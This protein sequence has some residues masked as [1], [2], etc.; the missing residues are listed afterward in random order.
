MAWNLPDIF[1]NTLKNT[2]ALPHPII[3]LR[4]SFSILSLKSYKTNKKILNP[5]IFSSVSEL[6]IFSNTNVNLLYPTL[7]KLERHLANTLLNENSLVCETNSQHDYM[8]NSSLVANLSELHKTLLN[9]WIS[10]EQVYS[11]TDG[12]YKYEMETVFLTYEGYLNF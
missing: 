8:Q 6:K 5:K 9:Q 4:N 7:N 3:N 2:L 12:N 10:T 1:V 11:T